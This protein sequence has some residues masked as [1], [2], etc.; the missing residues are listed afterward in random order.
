MERLTRTTLLCTCAGGWERRA[1]DEARRALTGP[2]TQALFMRGN[3]LVTCDDDPG[4]ALAALAR[5]E[6]QCLGRVVALQV[7][8]GVSKNARGLE[9]LA[10]ASDLLPG[11]S[12]EGTFKVVCERRGSH[13]WTSQDAEV[14]VA[15]RVSARTGADVDMHRP[16]QT[17]SVEVFQDMALLGVAWRDEMLR[18][19]IIRTRK[20]APGRRPLNRAELKLREAI[21]QFGLELPPTGRA[22]DIGAAPGGWT[23][24]LAGCMAEVVAVDPGRLNERVLAL[25]NVRHLQMRSEAL[26]QV[27]GLGV[28]DVVVDDMNMDPD[29]SA[30]VLCDAAHLVRPGGLLVMTVKFVTQ[31][32]SEHLRAA[33]D[34][35]AG[36]YEGLEARRVRHNGHETTVVGRRS[37]GAR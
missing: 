7:R 19:R 25:G 11:P 4:V 36:N 21:A 1:G 17:V 18:K 22:L 32:R 13:E 23:Q 31:R 20:Y 28:F 8:C 35:L 9:R 12:A 6:T 5:A 27:P 33:L 3:L 37:G 34:V 2:D 16:E 24:V 15:E 30:Q 14:A 26:V 29:R 10:E